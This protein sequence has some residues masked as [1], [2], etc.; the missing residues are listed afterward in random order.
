[1]QQHQ[2]GVTISQR[3]AEEYC[4]Y[5]R[6]KKVSEITSAM[7][8]SE[9]LLRENESGVRICERASRLRQISVRMTPSDILQKGE[10]FKKS[11]VKIDCIIGGNGETFPKV[12]AYEAKRAVRA[13]AKELT[14]ILSP[15][16]IVNCRY[17]DLRKEIKRV[18]RAAGRLPLKVRVEKVYS[19]A[20]LSRLARL[21]S[22]LGVYYFSLPYFEGCPRLKMDLS[23]GCL[24]EVS[25]VENLADFKKMVGAGIGRI[26]TSHAW[27]IYEEWLKEVEKIGLEQEKLPSAL[28]SE[29]TPEQGVKGSEGNLQTT[30]PTSDMPTKGEQGGSSM[31]ER[32]Q[33]N[34]QTG[35]APPLTEG[36]KTPNG[37]TAQSPVEQGAG[38]TAG[39]NAATLFLPLHSAERAEYKR[40]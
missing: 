1:M 16:L 20:T 36:E 35:Y 31:Q 8:R 17:N 34:L 26:V 5:K 39:T 32:G 9:S 3:E 14:L 12:K 38:R 11:P 24:L 25:G 10:I 30:L 6:Q 21:C 4:A 40:S 7:R 23:L 33:A 18:Q 2:S 19:Q 28:P 13:G 22:E 27:E 37:L 15:S 29:N